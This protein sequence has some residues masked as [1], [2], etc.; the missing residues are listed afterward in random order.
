MSTEEKKEKIK[1]KKEKTEEKTKKKPATK[2]KLKVNNIRK[3]LII[4]TCAL[5]TVFYVFYVLN[6]LE[7]V[8]FGIHI[9]NAT[10][11]LVALLAFSLAILIDEK[12][13]TLSYSIAS[14]SLALLMIVNVCSNLGFIN[15]PT[16]AVLKDYTNNSLI[17]LLTDADKFDFKFDIEKTY[18]YSDNVDEGDIISQSVN[19]ET[20]I[21]DIK[22]LMVVIS[23][24]PNYDKEVLLSNF[25]G[26]NVDEAIKFIDENFMNNVSFNFV[27]NNEME[28]DIVISQNIKGQ[29]KRNADL[30]FTVSL[31]NLDALTEY[32]IK[33]YSNQSLSKTLLELKRNGIKYD[34]RYEFSKEVK[35]DYVIEQSIKKGT[36]VKPNDDII[37][38]TVSYG[39]EI[40]VPDFNHK[41]SDDVLSWVSAN[42]L[43]V[44]FEEKH[45]IS[46][47][48]GKLIGIN[49]KKGESIS[50]GTKIIITTS[51]GPII[52]PAFSS[53]AHFRSWCDENRIG[54]DEIL[55]Y[56]NGVAKGNIIRT[57]V[58]TGDKID[59][60][61][62]RIT[63][64]ISQGAPIVVP[65]FVGKSKAAIQTQCRNVGLNCT[66]YY[67]GYNSAA[68]NTA[69]N[70]NVRSGVKVVSGTYVNIGLSSG[71]ARTYTVYIQDTWIG[72]SA[73][74]TTSIL[75]SKLSSLAPGVTFSIVQ[76]ESNTG[77][78]GLIHPSSPIKGGNQYTFTQGNKYTIWV[79]K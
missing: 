19:P 2:K 63:V 49:Y 42:N 40:K 10:F 15:L 60:T 58:N 41:T 14:I 9:F 69:L 26:L 3:L 72:N 65:N 73:A 55:E 44:A 51:L 47:E 17:S 38:L 52:V 12:R 50:E 78:S 6:S 21:S 76:K 29:V 25:V 31:G 1:E 4:I 43:K 53:L 67:V 24:G 39:K 28:R 54:F 11:L 68:A 13:K 62:N 48:K 20:K 32:E 59:P 35:R 45:H 23:N 8:N 36:K 30:V 66:F 37:I 75:K 56:N 22:K 46:Y 79:I 18:E 74:E 71:P 64:Y 16:L 70:Q 7:K 57:S 34:L 61:T 33:D 77:K 27:A 5:S